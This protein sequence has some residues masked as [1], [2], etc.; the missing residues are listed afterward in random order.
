MTICVELTEQE[1]WIKLQFMRPP[2]VPAW[3]AKRNEDNDD[4][5]YLKQRRI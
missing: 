1:M 2:K 4:L 5:E 3:K